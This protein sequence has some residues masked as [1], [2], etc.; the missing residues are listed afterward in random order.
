MDS[1]QTNKNKRM[2]RK[3]KQIEHKTNVDDYSSL[4]VDEKRK[5]LF[6]LGNVNLIFEGKTVPST[7]ELSKKFDVDIETAEK[8]RKLRYCRAANRLP[9]SKSDNN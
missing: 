5:Y 1:E 3:I 9:I 4:N 2:A 8:W 6:L 7:E